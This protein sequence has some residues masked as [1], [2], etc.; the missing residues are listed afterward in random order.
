LPV[1]AGIVSVLSFPSLK[2][3]PQSTDSVS[4]PTCGTTI[5]IIKREQGIVPNYVC[6]KCGNGVLVISTDDDKTS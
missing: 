3:E 6:P 2:E 4:C 5:P 1:L